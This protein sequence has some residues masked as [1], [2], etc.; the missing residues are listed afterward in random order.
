MMMANNQDLREVKLKSPS[1]ILWMALSGSEHQLWGPVFYLD[2][3]VS[4]WLS[5]TINTCLGEQLETDIKGKDGFPVQ[6]SSCF[7]SGKEFIT[8]VAKRKQVQSEYVCA[9]N[10]THMVKG[11][12][13]SGATRAGSLVKGLPLG[14]EGLGDVQS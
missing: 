9:R 1:L 11:T 6:R 10:N 5:H 3:L 13:N 2:S 12:K 4:S 7:V 14:D 8:R